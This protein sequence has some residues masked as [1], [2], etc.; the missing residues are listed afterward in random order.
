MHLKAFSRLALP[1]TAITH[2]EKADTFL[3]PKGK[4]AGIRVSD[5]IDEHTGYLK[6]TDEESERSKTAHPG[7]KQD[8]RKYLEYGEHKE[9]SWTSEKFIVHIEDAATLA[10][11]NYPRDKG[12]QLVW[13]FDHSSCHDALNAY[14]MNLKLGGTQPAMRNTLWCGTEY[15]LV[16]NLGVPKGLLQAGFSLQRASVAL[17]H[18]TFSNDSN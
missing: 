18:A 6:L 8:A 4:G 3:R 16:F 5:F 13:I 9:G 11:V 15:S 14:K 17:R 10:E 7:L 12:Y 2:S 1:I